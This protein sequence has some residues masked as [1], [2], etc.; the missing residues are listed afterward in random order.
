[1]K[2]YTKELVLDKIKTFANCNPEKVI[3]VGSH[4]ILTETFIEELKIPKTNY[5]LEFGVFSGDTINKLSKLCDKIYG[6]D[7]FDGLP[8]DWADNMLKGTFKVDELP[9]VSD[10]VELVVGLFEESIPKFLKEHNVNKINFINIDCDLYSSTK[11]IFKY[12]GKYIEAGT[13][14]HFDEFFTHSA[15]KDECDA[16]VEFI[17]EVDL[18]FDIIYTGTICECFGIVILIN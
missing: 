2:N 15:D 11:T 8:E 13:Y 5:W 6:F 14:I 1:M 7:S 18:D 17:N 10:N 3:Q 4:A 16:F 9:K 12:I